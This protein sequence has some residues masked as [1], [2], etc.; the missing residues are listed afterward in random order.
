MAWATRPRLPM[1]RPMSDGPTRTV[2]PRQ[3]PALGHVDAHGVAVF[4]QRADQ[5]LEHGVGGGHLGR[6]GAA[7]GH[8]PTFS[9]SSAAAA[10]VSTSAAVSSASASASAAVGSAAGAALS[11]LAAGFGSGAGRVEA[12][13]L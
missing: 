6:R 10:S 4:D 3:R 11:A 5:V 13:P 12:V 9:V 1:T 8:S 2:E 7:V